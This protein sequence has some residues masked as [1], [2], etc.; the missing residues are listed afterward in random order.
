MACDRAGVGIRVRLIAARR[1]ARLRPPTPLGR[2]P[3]SRHVAS[4]PCAGG[5]A[6]RG[7]GQSRGVAHGAVPLGGVRDGVLHL[8]VLLP[9]GRPTVGI[10]AARPRNGTNGGARTRGISAAWK[11]GSITGTANG[12]TARGVAAGA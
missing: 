5:A 9:G 1:D 6:C 7:D 4:S 2:S 10:T 12:P 11:A 8:W 3:T